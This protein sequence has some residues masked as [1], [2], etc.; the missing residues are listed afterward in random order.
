MRC[1]EENC[2]PEGRS[3]SRGWLARAVPGDERMLRACG[4]RAAG[5]VTLKVGTI[6]P[7]CRLSNS[8]EAAVAPTGRQFSVRLKAM[9]YRNYNNY[10][11]RGPRRKRQASRPRRYTPGAGEE[12]RALLV[13]LFAPL[14]RWLVRTLGKLRPKPRNPPLPFSV[15]STPVGRRSAPVLQVQQRHTPVRP[16]I[17]ALP[18]RK[19]SALLTKGSGASGIRCIAP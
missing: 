19:V 2:P 14:G 17:E 13:L 1:G 3:L 5:W 11:Y 4:C 6:T 16:S 9:G 7:R 10:N 12:F 15:L 18:Y 8:R